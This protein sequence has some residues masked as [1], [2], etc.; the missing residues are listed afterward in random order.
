VILT[1]NDPKELIMKEFRGKVAVITG[2]ASG[3]GYAISERCVKEGMKVVVADIEKAALTQAEKALKSGGANILTVQTDVSKAKDVEVLARKAFDAYGKVHLLFNNAGVDQHGTVW[4]RTLADWQWVIGVNLWGVIHGVRFFVPMMLEQNTEGHIVNTSSIAGLISGPNMGIYNA[5]KLGV[6]SLSQ[7]LYH[8][9]AMAGSKIKV[10]VLCPGFVNTRIMDAARNRPVELQNDP[11]EE[12]REPEFGKQEQLMRE[13]TQGGMSP[14][15][16]A[17]SVFDAII[18]E[19]FYIFTHPE[20]KDVVR[21]R[22][23]EILLER[24]PSHLMR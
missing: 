13:K 18:N 24:N 19:K 8:E 21:I 10:S 5:S 1:G 9:L 14:N 23:E 11:T 7:T 17:D 12:K 22:M 4:E 20:L 3:I 2:G 6:L 15:Q 16:V